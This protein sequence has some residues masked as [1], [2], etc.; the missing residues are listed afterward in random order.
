M[1]QNDV[2][3]HLIFVYR[4]LCLLLYADVGLACMALDVV[5]WVKLVSIITDPIL[6]F[7]GFYWM[8][9][10]INAFAQ[11]CCFVSFCYVLSCINCIGNV[12]VAHQSGAWCVWLYIAQSCILRLHRNL[13]PI[14]SIDYH[15]HSQLLALSPAN[16]TLERAS[17]VSL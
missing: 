11:V 6:L 12:Y 13:T 16:A 14:T 9:H 17:D 1:E 10:T 5:N 8:K 4:C 15:P 7:G 3:R 2:C